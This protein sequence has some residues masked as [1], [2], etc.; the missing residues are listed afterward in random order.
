M[1]IQHRTIVFVRLKK[2]SL[3]NVVVVNKRIQQN[4]ISSLTL[5][6]FFQKIFQALSL[7][8]TSVQII[9][10]TLLMSLLI[11]PRFRFLVLL[12]VVTNTGEGIY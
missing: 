4:N 1:S 11:N 2:S 12:P 8:P 5:K 10:L 3:Q 9:T 7:N 6:L